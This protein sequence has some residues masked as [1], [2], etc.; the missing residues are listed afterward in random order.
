MV[1]NECDEVIWSASEN[2]VA[3]Q[4][5][6]ALG[7]AKLHRLE[8]ASDLNKLRAL[9]GSVLPPCNF[10]LAKPRFCANPRESLAF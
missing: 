3:D 8:K 7:P 2:R 6:A 10:G 9:H 5:G 4:G 1:A